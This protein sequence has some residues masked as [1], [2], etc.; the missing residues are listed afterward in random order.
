MVE[1]KCVGQI[2]YLKETLVN[3]VGSQNIFKLIIF[4]FGNDQN[5]TYCFS[6]YELCIHLESP[7]THSLFPDRH[8]LWSG[9]RVHSRLWLYL[10]NMK[11]F[12]WN[13]NLHES[14]FHYFKV[15][16]IYKDIKNAT[17]WM[18]YLC[19][20]SLKKIEIKRW[21]GLLSS[22]LCR[23]PVFSLFPFCGFKKRI[24]KSLRSF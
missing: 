16:S 13:T 19:N 8:F 5:I 20:A 12:V 2:C 10:L 22:W 15:Y 4:P 6:S 21:L 11:P 7:L 1:P 14:I 24:K 23:F 18:G 9:S 17:F 3:V